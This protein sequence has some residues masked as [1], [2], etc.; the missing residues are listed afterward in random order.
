MKQQRGFDENPWMGNA[1]SVQLVG[2]ITLNVWR[3][4]RH[5]VCAKFAVLFDDG[6]FTLCITSFYHCRLL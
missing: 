6:W 5:E 3:L 1:S 4:M 2:R